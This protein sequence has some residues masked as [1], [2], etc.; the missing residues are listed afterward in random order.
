MTSPDQRTLSKA[1]Q[2]RT[3]PTFH[4]ATRLFPERVREDTYVLYAFL[5]TADEVVD[6]PDTGPPAQQRRELERIRAAA[7]GRRET[8]DPVL[9][10]FST[11]RERNGISDEE[12]DVF[13]DAMLMDVD[14]DD[15]ETIDAVD[16]YV[17][18]SSVAV[19]QMMLAIM[20]TTDR[21]AARPHAG[22]L[23]EAFQLTNFVR[24]VREDVLERD[25]VYLP[26]EVL[27]AH[28]VE[29]GD[30]RDLRFTDAIG[31]A[32]A[33]ELERIEALYREGV[34]GIE[35]LPADCQFPVL[36]AAVF[37]AE[38]HRR[39]REYGYDVVTGRP[40]LRHRDRLVC[41]ARTRWHWRRLDDPEAVFEAV[42]AVPTLDAAA[43]GGDASRETTADRSTGTERDR[44]ARADGTGGTSDGDACPM[45]ASVRR[46][47]GR[48]GTHLG[49]RSE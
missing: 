30:V 46:V 24:D 7:L 22:A 38:H 28:G 27:D 42:S 41:Y 34:A 13:V 47:A 3:G 21:E 9:S 10:A 11:V 14:K 4:F 35:Y 39:I 44:A 29:R 20:G 45:T 32:V 17:R 18:G 23:A 6:G 40:T 43:E 12:V 15:Y 5:R 33:A 36:L 8:D 25:R 31:D 48:L 19:G 2:R 1:I 49:V 16:E 37:Y 26:R